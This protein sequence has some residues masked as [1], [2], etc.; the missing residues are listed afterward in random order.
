MTLRSRVVEIY[1]IILSIMFVYLIVKFLITGQ[2]HKFVLRQEGTVN[3]RLV[4]E[5]DKI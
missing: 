5:Q 3:R 1:L 4:H 2:S